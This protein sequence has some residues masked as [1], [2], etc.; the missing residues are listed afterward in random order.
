MFVLAG[1]QI[2]VAAIIAVDVVARHRILEDRRFIDHYL[3]S[4]LASL[5]VAVGSGLL[6]LAALSSLG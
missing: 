6:A 5:S 1:A 3:L 2:A 4:T